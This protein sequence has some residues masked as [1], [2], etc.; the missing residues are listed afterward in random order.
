MSVG[1]DKNYRES[2]LVK[3][4]TKKVIAIGDLPLVPT[5]NPGETVDLLKFCSREKISYS[6]QLTKLVKAGWVTFEK[7]VKHKANKKIAKNEIGL[8][9]TPAEEDEIED[10]NFWDRDGTTI[11][12]H[13]PGD[14]FQLDPGGVSVDIILDEDDM[15][16]DDEDALATQQSIKAYVDGT[17][18]ETGEE[19]TDDTE[20]VLLYGKDNESLA[21]PI[22]ISGVNNDEVRIMTLDTDVI[23]DNILSE[24]I[25]ANIQLSLMTDT[26]IKGSEI[27]LNSD[28]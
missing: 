23:L 14:S 19:I 28:L 1:R 10:V 12:P 6:I 15:V 27:N 8:A 13:D 25:K 26:E 7:R 22:G 3:N 17:T 4:K 11:Y 20:G 24:L 9:I 18:V 21:Q 5:I 16:S 2:W